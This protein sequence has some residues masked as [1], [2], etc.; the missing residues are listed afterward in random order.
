M[1]TDAV[2]VRTTVSIPITY[3]ITMAQIVGNVDAALL[4]ALRSKC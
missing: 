4:S 1:I 3:V 2:I